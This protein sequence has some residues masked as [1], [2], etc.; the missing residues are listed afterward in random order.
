MWEAV[1]IQFGWLGRLEAQHP[2]TGFV[3]TYQ[4]YFSKTVSVPLGVISLRLPLQWSHFVCPLQVH[5][6]SAPSASLLATLAALS[7]SLNFCDW[8]DPVLTFHPLLG[9]FLS[10]ACPLRWW[11]SSSF[12]PPSSDLSSPL[13]CWKNDQITGIP[14][15]GYLRIQPELHFFHHYAPWDSSFLQVPQTSLERW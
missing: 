11:Y 15:F 5:A 3:D 2:K 13:L 6:L 8:H 7:L 12:L 1:I 4:I 10:S 14:G 9:K